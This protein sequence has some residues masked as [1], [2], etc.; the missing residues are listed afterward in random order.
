MGEEWRLERRWRKR[1]GHTNPLWAMDSWH[2]FSGYRPRRFPVPDVYKWYFLISRTIYSRNY[3]DSSIL[4]SVQDRS[5]VGEALWAGAWAWL[6]LW[7][8]WS[9][10][11]PPGVPGSCKI[12]DV[13]K[14]YAQM[15]LFYSKVLC[16]TVVRH[17]VLDVYGVSLWSVVLYTLT[18]CIT[19]FFFL[20]CFLYHFFISFSVF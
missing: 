10:D 14:G 16:P 12:V 1:E 20:L 15:L 11:T 3:Y 9:E 6:E 7:S 13:A 18:L 4:Y 5:W 2:G 17:K 19:R 8:D